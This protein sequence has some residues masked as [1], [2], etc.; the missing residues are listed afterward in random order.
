MFKV[1]GYNVPAVGLGTFQGESGNGCV[2]DAVLMALSVGYRHIDTAS[3]Y[4][5][6]G[7]VGKAIK[8]SGVRRDEIFVTTKL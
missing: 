8:A 6:E 3:A 1:N 4:G 5:N 2:K 7:D